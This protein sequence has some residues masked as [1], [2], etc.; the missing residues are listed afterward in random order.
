MLIPIWIGGALPRKNRTGIQLLFV[1]AIG[2]LTVPIDIRRTIA[3]PQTDESLRAS[4]HPSPGWE[5]RHSSVR[6]EVAFKLWHLVENLDSGKCEL[7]SSSDS[8]TEP[9]DRRGAPEHQDID[10][11]AD[12]PQKVAEMRGILE[13]ARRAVADA[14]VSG[15]DKHRPSLSFHSQADVVICHARDASVSG[16][17]LVYEPLAHKDTLGCWSHQEDYATW[18]I[19]IPKSGEYVLEIL[20]GCGTDS[21]GAQVEIAID[22]ARVRFMVEGTGHFQRFVPRRV[23]KVRLRSGGPRTLSVKALTKPGPAVMDLRRV[24]LIPVADP[25][26]TAAEEI[27]SSRE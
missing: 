15:S 3:Q 22:D 5:I 24:A 21:A 1:A 6:G 8:L 10:V 7:F 12:Y 23:G 19:E 11:S 2:L 9:N 13:A 17:T 18:Q 16:T 27:G 25:E 14:S 26:G 4:S 20:Q